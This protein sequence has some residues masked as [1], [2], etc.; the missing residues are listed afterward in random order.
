MAA[1]R[2][3]I[4]IVITAAAGA[5]AARVHWCGLFSQAAA[6]RPASRPAPTAQQIVRA[7]QRV[8]TPAMSS[9]TGAEALEAFRRELSVGLEKRNVLALE[10]AARYPEHPKVPDFMWVR[11]ANRINFF[12]EAEKVVRET[13]T[14]IAESKSE[15]FRDTARVA[16]AMAGLAMIDIEPARRREW[17]LDAAN[18]KNTAVEAAPDLLEQLALQFEIEPKAQSELL[19]RATGGSARSRVGGNWFALN[20]KIGTS[21]DAK[22]DE[23]PGA[24]SALDS[25]KGRFLLLHLA[26]VARDEERPDIAAISELLHGPA[27]EN[28]AVVTLESYAD[29]ARAGETR[30]RAKSEG[31]DW[32]FF[33][34]ARSWNATFSSTLG[35]NRTPTFL[36]FDREGNLAA[37]STRFVAIRDRYRVLAGAPK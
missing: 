35:I 36:L 28:L 7:F 34:D 33:V 2:Y 26:S 4:F 21:L 10:L 17:V 1:L 22:L 18:A 13:E 25:A 12:H 19:A 23:I 31:I 9:G 3:A 32:P 11:W 8:K 20:A 15:R 24:K 14:A 30:A 16:R 27:R 29:A 6:S 5:A 37:F